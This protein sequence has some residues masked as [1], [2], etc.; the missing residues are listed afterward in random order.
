MQ[1]PAIANHQLSDLAP[2]GIVFQPPGFG[3][4]MPLPVQLTWSGLNPPAAP[5]RCF[6][7]VADD[8]PEAAQTRIGGDMGCYRQESAHRRPARP[9]L[10]AARDPAPSR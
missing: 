5:K 7:R 8:P 4:I 9:F 3:S 6:L 2:P 10:R 1:R